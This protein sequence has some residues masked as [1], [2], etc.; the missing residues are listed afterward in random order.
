MTEVLAKQPWKIFHFAGV[1]ARLHANIHKLS[2]T[3]FPSQKDTMR[4]LIHQSKGRLGERAKNIL[5]RFEGLPEGYRLCHNDFH[6][7]NI[8][9]SHRGPVLIDW[10]EALSGHPYADV[11]H[12]LLVQERPVPVPGK[13]N[14]SCLYTRLHNRHRRWFSS[15]YVKEYCKLT[16]ASQK[17]ISKWIL[18]VSAARMVSKPSNEKDWTEAF[19]HDRWRLLKNRTVP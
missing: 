4:F 2:G 1:F 15:L 14:A 11:V 10:A 12:A 3:G 5:K 6:Q 19:I 9:F 8:I 18:P 17:E 16:G 13:P 7:E